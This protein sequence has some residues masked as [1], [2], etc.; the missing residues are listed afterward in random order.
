M[1]ILM[2]STNLFT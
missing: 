1:I 2:R